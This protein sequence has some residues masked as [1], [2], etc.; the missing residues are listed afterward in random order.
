MSAKIDQA[1]VT[2]SMLSVEEPCPEI[3]AWTLDEL[4]QLADLGSIRSAHADSN[5][6]GA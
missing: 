6:Q 2:D 1:A 3:D 4:D 5:S